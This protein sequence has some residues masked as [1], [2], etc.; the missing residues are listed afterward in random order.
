MFCFICRKHN[1]ENEKNKCKKFN[2]QAGIR[3]KRKAVEE[4]AN[5]QQHKAA[6]MCE[7]IN[8]TSPFQAELDR[9]EQK[10]NA[11]YYNAFLAIYWLAKE[12]LP[13]FKISS[14]LDV[15]EQLGLTDMKY[16]QHRSA[17]SFREMLL[18][19]GYQIK[20][21]VAEKCRKANWFGLLCDEVCDISNQ[22]Q[23]LTFIKYV[24][25]QI[26]KATTDFLSANDLFQ[27]SQS[28][29]ANTIWT[30]LNKQL[31]HS[32]LEKSKLASFASD[33]ASVMTGKKNG[34]AAKLRSDNKPLI[35]VH[36][37]AH[38]LA[39]ACGDANN[40]VSYILTM[41]KI[42]IQLWSP[43][44]NSPKKAA[45]YAKAVMNASELGVTN[46]MTRRGKKKL[47]KRFHKACRTRWLSTER[48]I[49]GVYND[50]AALTQTLRQLKEENDSAAIGLLKQVGNV[51]FLGT[52]YLLNEAIPIL[53]HLSRAFQ[54]GAVSFAAIDPA[55]KFTLD[56]LEA[57][58]DEEKPLTNLKKDHSEGGRLSQ[59]DMRPLGASDEKQLTTLTKAYV[60]ALKD[61]INNR[62]D[63]SI[64][65]LTAFRIF[66]PLAVPN[67]SEPVFKEYGMKDIVILA[68]HFYQEMEVEVKD[69]KKEELICEWRKFKYNLLSIKDNIPAEILTPPVKRNLIAQT[70]T[71]WVLEYLMKMRATFQYLFPLLLEMAELCLARTRSFLCQESED[72]SKVAL[73]E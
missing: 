17:G 31:E 54:K 24:D 55:I 38:R 4:H 62:F 65:V 14:F 73:K 44:K 48:A 69:E 39:L 57:I 5:S 61:N 12:E 32:K 30:V 26:N 67:R 45:K 36:C 42:L 41:E 40:S 35:N 59:C 2:L 47:S 28:A 60:A 11:V 71:E 70:P 6:I 56:E 19:L 50:F 20:S 46:A 68:D 3:F 63:G 13:N 66:D 21:Q 51:K 25:P 53:A 7:L 16:F 18:A 1:T 22:E 33:G 10:N 72:A 52:V 27:N 58:V 37:I 29:D 8:R 49:E 23:L 9:K 34:V 15:L 64:P 43:F